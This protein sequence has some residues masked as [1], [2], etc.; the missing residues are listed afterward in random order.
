M[1]QACANRRKGRVVP[2]GGQFSGKTKQRTQHSSP[3]MQCRLKR[4][5]KKLAAKHARAAHRIS[6]HHQSVGGPSASEAVISSDAH[7]NNNTQP[8]EHQA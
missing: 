7:P 2:N 4:G 8:K 3:A 6:L 5:A 1:S